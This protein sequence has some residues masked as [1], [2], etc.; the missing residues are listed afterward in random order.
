MSPPDRPPPP[1][2]QAVHVPWARKALRRLLQGLEPPKDPA[3]IPRR[4]KRKLAPSLSSAPIVAAEDPTAAAGTGV[5]FFG[6]GGRTALSSL[7][8]QLLVDLLYVMAELAYM[9]EG[10]ESSAA[11]A[12]LSGGIQVREWRGGQGKGGGG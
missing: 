8:P 1:T 2:A 4:R 6:S 11:F 10:R 5:Q 9:P 7:S 3:H 12:C